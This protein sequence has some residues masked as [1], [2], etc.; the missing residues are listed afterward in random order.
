MWLSILQLYHALK[1]VDTKGLTYCM[2]LV[3]DV[4]IFKW[5]IKKGSNKSNDFNKII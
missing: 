4:L 2:F 3:T 5:S 1:Q